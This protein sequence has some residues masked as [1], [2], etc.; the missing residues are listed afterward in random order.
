MELTLERM[1]QAFADLPEGY[2]TYE[3]F[4]SHRPIVDFYQQ[5]IQQKRQDDAVR[6]LASE[7]SQ[8]SL[9]QAALMAFLC[10]SLVES[11]ASP[12]TAFLPSANLLL[13]ILQALE[14]YCAEAPSEVEEGEE[15]EEYIAASTHFSDVQALL[16]NL[17]KEPKDRL[18]KLHRAADI[19]VLP[20]MA[21]LMR[22]TENHRRFLENKALVA[23]IRDCAYNNTLEFSDLHYLE[24]ATELTYEVIVVVLPTSRTGLLV[25]IHAANN[26]FHALTLLQPL[27]A[28]HAAA[29]R[30][31][32]VNPDVLQPESVEY[33][34]YSWLSAVAYQGGELK[35]SL[36]LAWGEPPLY[37]HPRRGGKV[38]LFAVEDEEK[39]YLKRSWNNFCSVI[40]EEQRASA[41]F[42][43][44]LTEEEVSLYMAG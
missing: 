37:S 13:A 17:S 42:I 36:A 26:T 39:N 8:K 19:L 24:M 41:T 31:G 43:R 16:A 9:P 1:R 40:H 22:S 7:F 5:S 12:E 14:P 23:L 29:L 44:Y 3:E 11:G 4:F 15:D 10:G 6:F 35:N 34:R 18:D 20:L 30:L 32:R 25:R 38:V 21:M 27:M 33:A 28:E 2:V